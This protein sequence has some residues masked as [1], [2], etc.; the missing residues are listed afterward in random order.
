MIP[1]A[2]GPS[3]SLATLQSNTPV[4]ASDWFRRALVA[5]WDAG[6]AD[7]IDP[8][9]LAGQCAHETGWGNFGG[10]VTPDMG[11]TCGLKI[12][13]P[14]GDRKEDHA[15]FPMVNGY[16]IAGAMA[17]ADHLRLYAG[18]PVDPRVTDDPRA[19]YVQP[20]SKGFGAARYVI[21]LGG[22]WAPAKSYGVSV[23]S[24]IEE[25]RGRVV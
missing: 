13:N 18:L 21:D 24:K 22:L 19:L 12:R 23:E 8:A 20:G 25:L 5:L 11:N 16:P 3:V 15:S 10:A 7:G 14:K 1:I 4:R 6:I 9:V 17:H 2:N